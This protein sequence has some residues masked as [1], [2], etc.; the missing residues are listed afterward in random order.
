M[1]YPPHRVLASQK[2]R[3]IP[4]ARLKGNVIPK[5]AV[6]YNDGFASGNEM[7][8]AAGAAM[9]EALA[10]STPMSVAPAMLNPTAPP[11]TIPKRPY[12]I[13]IQ[14]AKATR[15]NPTCRTSARRWAAN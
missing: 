5:D 11:V 8:I 4:K 7:R 1:V 3:G 14:I 12:K 15:K 10:A 2:Y 6:R 13:G 9:Y